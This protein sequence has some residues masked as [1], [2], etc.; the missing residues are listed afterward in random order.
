MDGKIETDC[1]LHLRIFPRS[2]SVPSIRFESWLAP[3]IESCDF[4]NS[5]EGFGVLALKRTFKWNH[6]LSQNMITELH[7][8]SKASILKSKMGI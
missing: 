7:S 2:D 8:I 4:L 6:S 3:L 1:A 5:I